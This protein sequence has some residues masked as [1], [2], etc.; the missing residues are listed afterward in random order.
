MGKRRGPSGEKD[1]AEKERV[2]VCQHKKSRAFES[3]LIQLT[4]LFC[5]LKLFKTKIK[6]SNLSIASVCTHMTLQLII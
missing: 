5:V 2:V 6:I 4:P 1:D 3:V